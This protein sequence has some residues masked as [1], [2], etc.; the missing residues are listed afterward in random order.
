L[1]QIT[2]HRR[3]SPVGGVKEKVLGTHRAGVSKVIIPWVNWKDV[4][5]EVPKVV[6]THMQFVLARMVREVLDAAFEGTLPWHMLMLIVES[7]L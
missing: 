1:A 6:R 5:L 3:V 4:E 2:L 7:R